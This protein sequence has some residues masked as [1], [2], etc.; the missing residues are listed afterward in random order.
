MSPG[1]VPVDSHPPP[2]SKAASTTHRNTEPLKKSGILDKTFAFE[3]LTPVI[4]R[5]YPTTRIVEDVL[6]A[7]NADELLR[8]IAITSKFEQ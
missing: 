1:A 6:N 5:E 3:E 7:P 8:D 2:Q 4:G